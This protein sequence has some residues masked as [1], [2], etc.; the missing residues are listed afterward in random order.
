M[1]CQKSNMLFHR[2]QRAHIYIYIYIHI[3]ISRRELLETIPCDDG[4]DDNTYNSFE[5]RTYTP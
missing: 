2:Q 5:K 3:H 1:I 4:D